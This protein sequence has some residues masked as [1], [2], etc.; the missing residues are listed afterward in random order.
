LRLQG[1]QVIDLECNGRSYWFMNRHP[2]SEEKKMMLA[3]PE[4][5]YF[6]TKKGSN[7]VPDKVVTWDAVLKANSH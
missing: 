7:D 2:S 6:L 4:R 1:D 5:V 3:T